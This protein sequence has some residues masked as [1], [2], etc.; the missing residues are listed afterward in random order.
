MF[1]VAS[2]SKKQRNNIIIQHVHVPH[3][4]DVTHMSALLLYNTARRR[5]LAGLFAGPGPRLNFNPFSVLRPGP[6]CQ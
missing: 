5:R 6:A 2:A 1:I 3:N 4:V